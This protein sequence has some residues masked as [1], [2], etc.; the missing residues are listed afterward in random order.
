MKALKA[1]SR[2]E[3]EAEGVTILTDE[4][5]KEF[6]KN[7]DFDLGNVEKYVDDRQKN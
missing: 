4:E 5:L 2:E 7:F 3:L 6:F 1:P